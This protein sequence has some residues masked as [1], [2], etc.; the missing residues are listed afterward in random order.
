MVLL[1]HTST[2]ILPLSSRDVFNM[3]S[4]YL[5]KLFV[6]CN[7][8]THRDVTLDMSPTPPS[9]STSAA[10]FIASSLETLYLLHNKC[11]D[12]FPIIFDTGAS[13]AVHFFDKNDFVCNIRPL[14]NHRLGGLAN[15]LNIEGIST[16]K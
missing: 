1:S 13:L 5:P 7:F 2:S 10:V 11:Q 6:N 4:I 12:S 8:H 14:A 9:L 3:E 16:V 15:R